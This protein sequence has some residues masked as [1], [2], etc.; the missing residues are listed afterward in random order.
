MNIIDA[1]QGTVM[2]AAGRWLQAIS[3][4]MG[5]NTLLLL[6]ALIAGFYLLKKLSKKIADKLGIGLG[7]LLALG[8]IAAAFLGT[9]RARSQRPAADLPPEIL[10]A[11]EKQAA[12]AEE[13]RDRWEKFE[14]AQADLATLDA[15]MAMMPLGGGPMPMLPMG[16]G[17]PMPQ[18]PKIPIPSHSPSVSTHGT[19]GVSHIS[20]GSVT[21]AAAPARPGTAHTA[22]GGPTKGPVVAA[23][24]AVNWNPVVSSPS[25]AQNKPAGSAASAARPANAAA[26][27]KTSRSAAGV[28]AGSSSAPNWG[29]GTGTVH[30]AGT[31][32]GGQA[33]GF[34]SQAGRSHGRHVMSADQVAAMKQLDAVT[35]H[36]MNPGM[37]MHPAAVHPAMPAH[38]GGGHPAGHPGAATH[39]GMTGHAAIGGHPVGHR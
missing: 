38:A 5:G 3:G 10:A 28:T 6:A 13:T 36:Y 30:P 17:G 22:T 15:G 7:P 39:P 24:A 32:G 1:I 9:L 29:T 16:S 31:A 20:V 33:G 26:S 35:T 18:M 27:V 37:G 11:K 2:S 8:V 34:S 25:D 19:P 23:T 12:K 14:R 21:A 4:Q